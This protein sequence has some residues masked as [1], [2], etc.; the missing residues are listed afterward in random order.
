MSD[1]GEPE[2]QDEVPFFFSGEPLEFDES[3]LDEDSLSLEEDEGPSEVE[4]QVGEPADE[5][6]TTVPTG[7]LD[8]LIAAVN[9]TNEKLDQARDTA[10]Q[11]L[12]LQELRVIIAGLALVVAILALAWAMNT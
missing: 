6:K 3:A 4:W 1:S 9:K 7:K 8:E 12:T 11:G 10:K 2:G 5:I